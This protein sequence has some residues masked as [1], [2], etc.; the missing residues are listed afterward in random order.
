[1]FNMRDI[2]GWSAQ[3]GVKIPY[4]KVYRGG[5]FSNITN[6]GKKTFIEELGIKTEIDLRTNGT[7]VLNDDR[8]EYFSGGMWQ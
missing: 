1:M 2:G 6:D 5:Y 8:V 7:N 4:G 3:Q